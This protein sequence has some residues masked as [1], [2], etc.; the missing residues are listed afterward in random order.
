[1]CYT[2]NLIE[3]GTCQDSASLG[4]KHSPS[5]WA[6]VPGNT[7]DT[8]TPAEGGVLVGK[9]RSR[10][11]NRLTPGGQQCSVLQNSL[12]QGRE[13]TTDLHTES[14]SGAPTF[15]VTVTMTAKTVVLLMG[16]EGVRGGSI[17]KKLFTP[18]PSHTHMSNF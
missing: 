1:N 4:S 18:S 16:K 5:V 10:F 2:N 13:F 3:D 12:L 7:F 9:D 8:I 6:T 17:N 11:L 14:T 15:S